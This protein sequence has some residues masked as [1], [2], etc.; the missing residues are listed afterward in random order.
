MRS[1]SSSARPEAAEPLRALRVVIRTAG[2]QPAVTGKTDAGDF[3]GF[4]LRH[5]RIGTRRRLTCSRR[6][7]F[8]RNVGRIREARSVAV[9]SFTLVAGYGFA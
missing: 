2:C 7:R 5:Q 9:K 8:F 4:Q 6:V 1:R 3:A